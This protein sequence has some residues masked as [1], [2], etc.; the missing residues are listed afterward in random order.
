ML[1]CPNLLSYSAGLHSDVS[2]RVADAY[3]HHSLPVH[4]LRSLVVPAVEIFPFERLN[5]SNKQKIN[6]T[7]KKSRLIFS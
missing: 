4:V 1:S 5:A 7:Q 2:A 3:H 6:K